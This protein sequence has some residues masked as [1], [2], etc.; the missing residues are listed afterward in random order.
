MKRLIVFV[1]LLTALILVPMAVVLSAPQIAWVKYTGNPVLLPGTG[2]AW[3]NQNVFS[4]DIVLDGTTYKM[5]YTGSGKTQ[6]RSDIGYA[7]STDGLTWVKQGSGPVLRHGVSPAWDTGGVSA[8]SVL[9]D[10]AAPAESRWKMWYT[11][12]SQI[13]GGFRIGYATSPDG[14]TWT[15]YPAIVLDVSLEGADDENVLSPHVLIRNGGYH[16]WYSGRGDRNQ[17]F[18]ATSTD[19]IQ[20]TKHPSNPVVTLGGDIEWDNG[21]IAAPSVLVSGTGY[22]MWYQGYSR[23]TLQRYVGHATSP[24]GVVWTKDVLNPVVGLEPGSWDGYSIYYPSVGT[25]N[26]QLMMWYHGEE[27]AFAPQKI[28]VVSIDPLAVPTPLPTFPPL[29]TDDPSTPE[30]TPGPTATPVP[31]IYGVS[32]NDGA[33]FTNQVTVTL[34]IKAPANAPQMMVSNDGGFIG[35]QWETFAA[36]RPWILVGYGSYI[37]PRTVYVQMGDAQGSPQAVVS[38]DIILDVTAP[39]ATIYV[40]AAL[41]LAASVTANTLLLQ[42]EDDVSGAAS[43]RFGNQED[44]SGVAWEAFAPTKE[45][46]FDANGTVFAEFRDG[47]GNVSVITRGLLS[48]AR[49]PG[50]YLPFAARQ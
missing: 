45:W 19:G 42:V 28:G 48:D 18:Y 24:D 23:S 26:G 6:S 11:G 39:T 12:V 44:L 20:W 14:M 2:T 33:L 30:G 35:V 4:A 32:I 34:Q 37:L 8:P 31:N 50:L 7:T 5:W 21:E 49:A 16:M 22:E 43:M 25:F 9:T 41:P 3:D 17:I 36:T 46:T 1:V 27:F 38:D 15:K 13:G 47:A 29:P 40:Q 10:P